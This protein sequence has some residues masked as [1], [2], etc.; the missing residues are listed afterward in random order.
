MKT[1]VTMAMV[2]GMA[3]SGVG[4]AG[5]T[6]IVYYEASVIDEASG[7]EL[8]AAGPWAWEDLVGQVLAGD[9]EGPA[10]SIV[11][12]GRDNAGTFY[13]GSIMGV[14]L[15]APIIPGE[16]ASLIFFPNHYTVSVYLNGEYYI[17]D[18]QL[19]PI[20]LDVEVDI[21]PFSVKNPFNVESCGKLPVAIMG[22]AELDVSLIDLASLKLA[23]IAPVGHFA[24]DIQGDG[25]MDLVLLFQDRAVAALVPDGMDGEVVG[26]TLTGALVDGTLITGADSITL[27]VPKPRKHEKHEKQ[28]KDRHHK[29]NCRK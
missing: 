13:S 1:L 4:Q 24:F 10:R 11:I 12:R 3:L 18:M 5:L 16:L 2:A 15:V 25:E 9:I 22:S 21:R 20:A 7:Q 23:T 28:D 19:R 14:D 6:D 27:Q 26:L 8:A 29:T 17:G